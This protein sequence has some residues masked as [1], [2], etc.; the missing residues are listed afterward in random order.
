MFRLFKG[1]REALNKYLLI[2]FL[3]IVSLGMVLTLAPI[4]LG[5]NPD[6]EGNVLANV[7]GAR[8]TAPD[9]ER[10]I[11]A[12]LRNSPFANDPQMVARMAS[13]VLDDMILRQAL[14][15]QAKKLGI[16]VS[17]TELEESIRAALFPG[18]APVDVDRYRDFIS[19]RYGLSVPQFEAQFREDLL[20][21]KMRAIITDGVRV[22]PADV[23]DEFL[24]RNTKVR[25]EYV[26]F[27]P[28]KYLQAVPVTPAALQKFFQEDPSKYKIPEE[29]RVRYVLIDMDRARAQV[30]VSEDDLKQY[31]SQHISDYQVS[32]RVKVSHILFKTEGKTPEEIAAV[33][34]TAREV[35]AKIKAGADFGE[36]AKKYSEDSSASNGGQIGWIVRGQTVKEFEDAAFSMK[37]GQV[38]D[39]IKTTYG[40]HIIEVLDKQTAHLQTFDEVKDQI[41]DQLMKERLADAQQTMATDLQRQFQADPQNFAATAQKNNLQVKETPL[42]RYNQPVQDF[43]NSESFHNLAFQLREGAVGQ[44]ISVPKGM[45]IIQMIQIVPEHLPKLEDVRAAVEQ[46]YRAAQSQVL[47]AQK[48]QEFA[49]K[50][51][52][53]DFK[54][55]AQSMGLTVKESKDFTQ[56]DFV[57][58]VGSGTQLAAAFTLPD[59]QTSD[60][61]QVGGNR[62]VFRVVARAAPPE[63]ELAS[64]QD[65]VAQEV[66][67]RKQN[68]AWE[69]YQ[70]NLKQQLQ[71][72]GK[73]KLNESAM[74]KFLATYQKS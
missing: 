48:A 53:G 52:S 21:E 38:S 49:A 29:R 12:R 6:V 14:W 2:F 57:E 73:L 10:N 37:P 69:I 51:K 66:L 26:L 15:S 40:F 7:G 58:G 46:D 9:L 54:K 43:G 28:S 23:R 17:D 63:S 36:M 4:N 60:A 41:R 62:V 44:A 31:Y 65:Q 3:S 22:T 56:R 45:A 25:I 5:D 70:Q 16:G 59:G 8:I 19:Q 50:A 67:A 47:A 24:K 34:K 11:Q 30:K 64:Q 61:V 68:L 39:L 35:L 42:F 71:A 13:I 27:D 72:S 32:D 74:K 1:K 55:V 18:G 33:E 20:L